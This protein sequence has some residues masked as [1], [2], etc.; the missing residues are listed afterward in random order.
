MKGPERPCS[1]KPQQKSSRNVLQRPVE[2]TANSGRTHEG[3]AWTLGQ[4]RDDVCY[5][6]PSGFQCAS[7]NERQP[8]C[9]GREE[10]LHFFP[11]VRDRLAIAREMPQQASLEES[12]K[13]RIEGAPG[14]HRLSTTK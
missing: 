12:I 2:P 14:N 8:L 1:I 7:V 9:D 5:V 6:H 11:Q 13:Q 3:R 4:R 10:A